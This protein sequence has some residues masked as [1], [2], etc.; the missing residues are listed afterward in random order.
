MISGEHAVLHGRH[1]LVGAVNQR[2]YV[3]LTPRNDDKITINSSLGKRLMAIDSIDSSRPFQ[4]IGAVLETHK[5]EFK[6]GFDL[7]ITAEFSAVVGLGSS[8]AITV[9]ALAAVK[10]YL[11]G[12]FPQRE[13][14]MRE[15][16]AIIRNVQ[17]RG[18]G[19]DIAAAVYGGILLYK[20]TPEIIRHYDNLPP[21]ELVY[22]GYKTP[23]A[24]VIEIVEQARQKSAD[25]YKA[26]F[27][28][29]DVCTMFADQALQDANWTALGNALSR[30]QLMMEMLGVCDETLSDI[31]AKM[32]AMPDITG[33]KISG[34][35]LGDCVLGIG[36][37]D[38][39]KW[40]YKSI[41][42]SL[43]THGIEQ[44]DAH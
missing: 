2:V 24:E 12:I 6:S 37:L 31:V 30:G 40:P 32:T 41:K 20:A 7:D 11:N 14:L 39:I 15:A 25:G 33:V 9:A 27:D 34:S 23:T 3:S 26:L 10:T 42:V 1:A 19:A 28:R 17:G 4:F 36:K 44:L 5:A 16:V 35:G 18:S 13:D 21:I 22:A 29:I 43:S 38:N 8:S